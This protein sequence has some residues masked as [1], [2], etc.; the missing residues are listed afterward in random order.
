MV[1]LV[2]G[3]EFRTVTG[4]GPRVA[5]NGTWQEGELEL[6]MGLGS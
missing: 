2:G 1:R 5:G 4:D 3:W 6:V